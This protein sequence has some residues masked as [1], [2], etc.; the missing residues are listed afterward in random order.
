MPTLDELIAQ[1]LQESLASGE[2]RGTPGWGKPLDFGDGYDETPAEL[3][4]PYKILKDAGFVPAEIEWMHRAIALKA[5]IAAAPDEAT[6]GPLRRELAEMQQ[7]IALRLEK[8]R[9]SGSL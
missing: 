2:L 1:H 8:L 3:R 9:A 6:A 5:Q 7:R 4:M